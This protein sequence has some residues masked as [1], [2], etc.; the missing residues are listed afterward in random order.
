MNP[1]RFTIV[2]L[3]HI[4]SPYLKLLPKK[5]MICALLHEVL[6]ELIL[7]F[8]LN[9][10]PSFLEQ[11]LE[12]KGIAFGLETRNFN[13]LHRFL[14]KHQ[15]YPEYLMTPIN[16]L[17]YQ[18]AP[19]REKVEECVKGLGARS[20]ILA[21]NTLASGTVSLEESINYLRSF[22]DHL[23]GVTSASSKPDRIR[24]NFTMLSKAFQPG[25]KS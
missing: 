24:D 2:F 10:L 22:E 12:K 23:Y 11:R 21:I 1:K 17:G 9:Q 25:T 13:Q 8:D 19:T 16:P 7:A 15:F 3:E 5:R 4:L 14:S 20:K 18:M 6:T